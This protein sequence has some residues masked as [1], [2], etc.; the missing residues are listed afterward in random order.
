MGRRT[1]PAQVIAN[2]FSEGKIHAPAS[3]PAQLGARAA[4]CY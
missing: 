4:L 1:S 3:A 2:T